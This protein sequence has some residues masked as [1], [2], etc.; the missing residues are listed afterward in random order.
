M[1][2][3][4]RGLGFDACFRP[5]A[6]LSRACSGAGLSPGAAPVA[7]SEV[8]NRSGRSVR[9]KN[10]EIRTPEFWLKIRGVSRDH[11]TSAGAQEGVLHPPRQ[12]RLPTAELAGICI[13]SK[14]RGWL[15]DDCVLLA[16]T[17]CIGSTGKEI[18]RSYNASES[19]PPIATV[20]AAIAAT[21]SFIAAV[22]Q[23]REP[24]PAI[25]IINKSRLLRRFRD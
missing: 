12:S 22:R 14:W 23:E 4:D 17:V 3:R 20:E 5:R 8:R 1:R 16:A 18:V 25:F 13:S 2:R 11:R 15:E 7:G 21:M 9:R 19:M 10:H 24:S 6:V